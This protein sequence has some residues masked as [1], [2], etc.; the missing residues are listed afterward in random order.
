[1]RSLILCLGMTAALPA[2]TPPQPPQIPQLRVPK[3]GFLGIGLQEVNADRA[4]ALKVPSDT[5]VE[6]TRILPDSP[7]DRAGLKAGDI[8]LQLNGMKIEGLE[9]FSRIIR[10]TPTGKDVKL[11]V[12]R[13]G[14][15]QSIVVK[16]GQHPAPQ[17]L[18]TPDMTQGPDVL[19]VFPGLRSPMLGVEAEALEGQLAQYFGVANGVLVRG[20]SKGSAAEKAGIRAGDVIVRIDEAKVA[21][22]ADISMRLRTL[23][24]KAV[25]V[26]LM[27]DRHEMTVMVAIDPPDGR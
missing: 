9:Q 8:V 14:A 21:T 15:T 12:F 10:D 17:I 3:G 25:P 2:Q 5:G 6:I 16:V 27:R 11:D 24:G 22:P 23:A 13:S 26:A 18:I 1:M 20:V 19:R 7:A 4:R